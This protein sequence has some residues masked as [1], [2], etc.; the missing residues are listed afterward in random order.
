MS[1]KNK[2]KIFKNHN[3]INDINYL[4]VE[5]LR[6]RNI[7][8]S[9]KETIKKFELEKNPMKQINILKKFHIQTKNK[10]IIKV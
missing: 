10:I 4:K 5:N 9:L 7:I 3:D 2:T 6:L 8:E 1:K